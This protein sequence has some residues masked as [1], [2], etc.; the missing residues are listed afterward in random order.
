MTDEARRRGPGDDTMSI[1][2]IK[3]TRIYQEIVRQVKA[4]AAGR[5]RLGQD[6]EFH[7]AIGAAAHKRAITRIAH[8]VMDLLRQSREESLNTPG[9]PTRSH[10]DHRR[11]LAA[12]RARNEAAARQAMIEHLQAVEGLVLGDDETPRSTSAPGRGKTP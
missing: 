3:S 10:E 12:I 11:L 1:A 9:R 7:S 4:V 8:A 5:T 6:A 2:P